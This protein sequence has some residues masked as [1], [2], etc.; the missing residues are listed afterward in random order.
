M[1]E[2][3]NGVSHHKKGKKPSGKEDGGFMVG[4]LGLLLEAFQLPRVIEGGVEI[5]DSREFELHLG[6]HW[7]P[8]GGGLHLGQSGVQPT[9]P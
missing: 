1:R 5:N 2:H 8:W 6:R 3:N 7:H 4:V 9:L